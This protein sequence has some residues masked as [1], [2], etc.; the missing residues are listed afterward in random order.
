MTLSIVDGVNL[1]NWGVVLD[2]VESSLV[3]DACRLVMECA[4]GIPL[5]VSLYCRLC[6]GFFSLHSGLTLQMGIP[7]PHSSERVFP[8]DAVVRSVLVGA[9]TL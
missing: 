6:V 8:S 3:A 4:Y 1:A 5:Y 7:S 9:D 2:V